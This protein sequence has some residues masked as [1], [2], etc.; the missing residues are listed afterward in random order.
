MSDRVKPIPDGYPVLNPYLIVSDGA[1][2][3]AFYERVFGAKLRLRLGGP[4]G[5]VGHAEL[6]VGSGLIMLADEYPD[7]GARSPATVGGSPV[8]LHIYTEDVDQAVQRAVEA[9]ARVIRPVEKAFYGDR[10][11]MMA[12]PFGH[13]W[14]IA[15]HVEDVSPEEIERRAV[16]FAG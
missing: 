2:A 16:K 6:A 14:S 15:T 13:L 9:G 3:I 12:D 4:G 1:A 7:M 5:K 11:G 10:T 8:I